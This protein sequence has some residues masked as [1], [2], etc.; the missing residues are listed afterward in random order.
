MLKHILKVPFILL[1]LCLVPFA[2][3]FHI[4]RFFGAIFEATYYYAFYK[5]TYKKEFIRAC[6]NWNLPFAENWDE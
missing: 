2:L 1:F 3:V 4:C 6:E 5:N